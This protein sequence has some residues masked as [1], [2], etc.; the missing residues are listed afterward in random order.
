M[1][2]LVLLLLTFGACSEN[3]DAP[4]AKS[5]EPKVP[6]FDTVEGTFATLLHAIRNQDLELYKRCFT[7][8]ANEGGESQLKLHAKDSGT[9]WA[10]L[11]FL[12]RGPQSLK[13]KDVDGDRTTVHVEAPEAKGGGIGRMRFDRVDDRWLIA[14]W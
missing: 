13:N 10:Q 7:A 12:F 2:I 11:Q 14:S 1:R 9:F 6:S 5:D 4:D 8:G 3:S